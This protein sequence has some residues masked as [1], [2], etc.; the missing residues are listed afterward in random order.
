KRIKVNSDGYFIN[1]GTVDIKKI[2]YLGNVSNSGT[3]S[4]SVNIKNEG[5]FANLSGGTLNIDGNF[6][7]DYGESFTNSGNLNITSNLINR[8][9]FTNASGGILDIDA[10]LKNDWGYT[11]NNSGE[12]NIGTELLNRGTFTN[13]SGGILDIDAKLANDWSCTF[14]N[15]GEINI[16]TEL[17]NQGTF[18]NSG[19]VSVTTDLKSS[20]TF[21]N[22]TGSTLTVGGEFEN[23]WGCTFNNSGEISIGTDLL[24]QGIFT[25]SSGSRLTVGGEFENDW[26]CTFSN[27]GYF[28]VEDFL[29]KGSVTNTDSFCISGV[30]DNSNNKTIINNGTF[31]FETTAT[32]SAYVVDYGYISGTGN[33]TIDL[34]LSGGKWHY[35]SIP[36]SGVSS[37]VFMGAALYS[38]N[39]HTDTWDAHGSGESLQQFKGYDVYFANNTTVTL[40][41]SLNSGNYSN[42][43]ITYSNDGFNLVGNPYYAMIDWR[44]SSGWTKSKLENATY[45]WDPDLQNIATYVNNSGTNG[46]SRYIPPMQAFFVKASTSGQN[47]SL[48][49]KDN[50]KVNNKSKNF[51]NEEFA[52]ESV[53]FTI[54]SFNGFKDE[55][56]VRFDDNAT[57]NYDSDFDASKMYSFN[58]IVPQIYTKIND[59]EVSINTLK[60]FSTDVKVQLNFKVGETGK[61]TLNANLEEFPDCYYVFVEDKKQEVVHNLLNGEY[62][63]YANVNDDE[64]RFVIHFCKQQ[65]LASQ[66]NNTAVEE[67]TEDSQLKVYSQENDVYINFANDISTNVTITVY[68]IDGK[69][70]TSFENKNSRNVK[71][72]IM[73]KSAYYIVN[74]KGEGI[75]HSEKIYIK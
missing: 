1:Y 11:F 69:K 71:I 48:T 27:A 14:N 8:G 31:V 47:A 44:K 33:A 2:V 29:N 59:K 5:T 4:F 74:V 73:E 64:D 37:N 42:T 24:N 20:G 19:D 13:A 25:N 45:I 32:A 39:E 65:Q 30:L 55:A 22:S 57:N 61:N 15:S 10:I 17:L 54:E 56:V 72:Q 50:S 36:L 68:S 58:K 6:T 46:G 9:T 12:I 7:I 21:T 40:D 53:R 41:G 60:K 38:Y 52:G 26:S 18:T 70:I 3:M 75:N 51:R 28:N 43:V 35:V 49:I 63:F 16:G 66:N 62:E 23:D 34:V 67:L